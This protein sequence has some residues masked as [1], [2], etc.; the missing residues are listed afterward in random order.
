MFGK[1]LSDDFLKQINLFCSSLTKNIE[2]IKSCD[3]YRTC[4]EVAIKKYWYVF[5]LASVVEKVQ[6]R[7]VLSQ[8][9]N[10]DAN[11]FSCLCC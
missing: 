7:R 10:N 2:F 8:V 3:E 9:K 5:V 4:K 6:R 1:N 11:T